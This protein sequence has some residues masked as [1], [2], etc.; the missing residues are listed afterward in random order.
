M[1]GSRAV[2]LGWDGIRLFRLHEP[3][4]IL[5]PDL[6]GRGEREFPIPALGAIIKPA[7]ERRLEIA[8]QR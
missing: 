6:V 8:M 2:E 3:S 1:K 4:L 7:G 5:E